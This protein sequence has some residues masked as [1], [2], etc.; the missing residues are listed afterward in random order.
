MGVAEEVVKV[1][2]QSIQLFKAGSGR[3]LLVLHDVEGSPASQGFVQDLAARFTV[4]L[5][6]HPGFGA[7]DRPAWIESVPDMAAF[8]GWFLQ[9]RGLE[10]V[11]VIGFGLGGWLAAEVA[12]A[13]PHA[14]SKLVL[15]GAT[16]I[17]PAV[18]EIAD[19]FIITPSQIRDL[20]FHDRSQAPEYAGLYERPVSPEEQYV[21][22]R[23]REMAVRICWKPYM[24]DPRLPFLL[25]R[26]RVP[27]RIVWGRQD[28]LVPLN[29]GELYHRAIPGSALAIVEGCGHMPQVER[30][31][32]FVRLALEF[33]A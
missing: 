30:P 33:L 2:G 21:A 28:R 7:S 23:N 13:C 20:A 16:G 24:H 10:G 26:V 15:V 11:P 32:E 31:A 6:S 17:R 12:V 4:H 25:P 8:Y 27:A 9:E 29:C 3:P 14:F 1:G 22:E 19:I 5:P 18:G